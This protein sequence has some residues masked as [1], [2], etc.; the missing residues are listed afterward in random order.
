PE[1]NLKQAWLVP[2]ASALPNEHGTAPGWWVDGPDGSVATLLPGP[3][4]EMR[5]MWFEAVVPRLERRGFGR[6]SVV[7]LFRLAGIGESHVAD[8]LGRE[9]LEAPNPDV[10]TFARNDAVD[11]RIVALGDSPDE[12]TTAADGASASVRAALADHVWAEG[13][14]S[15]SEVV[16][17]ALAD[18]GANLVIDE[19]GTAG[20]LV[21]L[22]GRCERLRSA[23]VRGPAGG[24]RVDRAGPALGDV[25]LS[26][27]VAPA[28]EGR[29]LVAEI[30]IGG[31]GLDV[32]ERATAFLADEQGL[33]RTAVAAA[34]A[35]VRALRNGGTAR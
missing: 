15:W 31:E 29:D 25:R 18:R 4:R 35:L 24:N 26:L 33:A 7:R 13:R 1:S 3:P 14:A 9:L 6:A 27:R 19:E 12:A 8:R 30:S 22:L 23:A 11:V 10:A 34:W 5:P 28:S 21:G 32:R 20:A 2:S 17:R 16:D